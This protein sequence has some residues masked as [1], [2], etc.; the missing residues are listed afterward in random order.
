MANAHILTAASNIRRAVDDFNLKKNE[1]R[2]NI[3]QAR[4]E[5]K[6]H[7]EE[8]RR[9]I[10]HMR[11]ENS[12]QDTPQN[13]KLANDMRIRSMEIDISKLEHDTRSFVEETSRKINDLD[14]QQ[15]EFNRL[16]SGLET[17]A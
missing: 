5:S 7:I 6:R 13:S 15:Q 12:Q 11:H 2:H 9:E 3:D 10:E 16:A 4:D 14:R 1:L 8:M 17:S